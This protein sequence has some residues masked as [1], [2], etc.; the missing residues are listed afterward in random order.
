MSEID[1]KFDV[2][3]ELNIL[4]F[5]FWLGYIIFCYLFKFYRE[6]V[7]MNSLTITE[8]DRFKQHVRPQFIIKKNEY[9][10]VKWFLKI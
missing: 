3:I 1:I 5:V 7:N 2:F 6:T 8:F 4:K 10:F 9:N